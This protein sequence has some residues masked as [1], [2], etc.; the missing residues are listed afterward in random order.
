MDLR[1]VLDD[2][3]MIALAINGNGSTRTHLV[4]SQ[5]PKQVKYSPHRARCLISLA[6]PGGPSAISWLSPTVNDGTP[7]RRRTGNARGWCM[8]A[9][10]ADHQEGAARRPND[11]I[12]RA[13]GVRTKWR[14]VAIGRRTDVRVE[15]RQHACMGGFQPPILRCSVVIRW[16]YR[17]AEAAGGRNRDTCSTER[18]WWRVCSDLRRDGWILDRPASRDAS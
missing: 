4:T 3:A 16:H 14:F 13:D 17:S 8:L 11:S 1:L 9:R 12:H 2:A 15:A 7:V 18:R 6:A 10:G 5:S